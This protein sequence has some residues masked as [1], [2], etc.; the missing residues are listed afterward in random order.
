MYK[1]PADA[2]HRYP[3]PLE[4]ESDVVSCKAHTDDIDYEF[5][6]VEIKKKE[7][8]HLQEW[9]QP[10][11]GYRRGPPLFH[12]REDHSRPSVSCNGTSS[13]PRREDY[14]G[15]PASFYEAVI[16]FLGIMY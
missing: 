2:A 8:R 4:A 3:P 14:P 6:F 11:H 13:A 16:D 1:N 15:P 7:K 5:S 10:V 9:A 12:R